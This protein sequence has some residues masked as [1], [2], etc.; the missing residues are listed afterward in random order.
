MVGACA[1]ATGLC[2]RARDDRL[3]PAVLA[4]LAGAQVQ[5]AADAA[6]AGG[7]ADEAVGKGA[8]KAWGDARAEDGAESQETGGREREKGTGGREGREGD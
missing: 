3:A 5:A 8:G 2:L 4:V 1:L 7:A 6:D